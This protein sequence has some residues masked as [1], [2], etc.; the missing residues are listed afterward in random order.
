VA[1]QLDFRDV[2]WVAAQLNLDKN[3]VYRYLS[4]GVLPGLQ[5]GRKWLISESTLVEHLK[6]EEQRQTEARRR[7]SSKDS[8][9]WR[10][11]ERFSPRARGVMSV[12]HAEAARH[13]LTWFGQE[14]LLYGI[15]VVPGSVGLLILER[16]GV[17]QA[18]IQGEAE[19]ILP[20]QQRG[21]VDAGGGEIEPTDR[22][23]S[24]LALAVDEARQW[25]HGYIGVEHLLIGMLLETEGPGAQ[26][27]TRLGLTRDGARTE[28][29]RHLDGMTVSGYRFPDDV[30]VA[31]YPAQPKRPAG[32][33]PPGS[34]QVDR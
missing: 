13:G 31:P 21:I 17:S 30:P 8:D 20:P 16:H 10:R 25:K 28:L 34:T 2:D 14:H 11:F 29:K 27:L 32:A 22:A 24:T 19:A 26:A 18:R 12:A 6:A 1:P 15:A 7:M 4:E 5:L 9:F 3:A 33:S 23:R